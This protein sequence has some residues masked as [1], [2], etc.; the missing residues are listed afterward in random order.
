LNSPKST[1]G[2]FDAT[3]GLGLCLALAFGAG[4]GLRALGPDA[5]APGSEEPASTTSGTAVD[6][7]GSAGAT[8]EVEA[9]TS[10]GALAAADGWR[11][12]R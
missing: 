9:R 12:S 5:E 2:G 8:V 1:A 7:A 4:T 6:G 11:E 10:S 3:G